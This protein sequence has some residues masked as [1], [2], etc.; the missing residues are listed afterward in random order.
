VSLTRFDLIN[1][2]LTDFGLSA[3]DTEYMFIQVHK[4]IPYIQMH[5]YMSL[6]LLFSNFKNIY[7]HFKFGCV[8]DQVMTVILKFWDG[9]FGFWG[10]FDVL[11]TSDE[12]FQRSKAFC[13]NWIGHD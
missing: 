9:E 11:T 13:R 10:P 3:L 2:L 4:S 6:F 8:I 1:L 7:S 5:T 12:I